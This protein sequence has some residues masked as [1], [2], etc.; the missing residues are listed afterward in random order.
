MAGTSSTLGPRSKA[1]LS[2]S[3]ILSQCLGV[4][5]YRSSPP[6]LNTFWVFVY[7][8]EALRGGRG[9]GISENL[10]PFFLVP[11]SGDSETTQLVEVFTSFHLEPPRLWSAW[12]KRVR[13]DGNPV[14]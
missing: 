10:A 12:V 5:E 1:G 6:P 2:A 7:V 13:Q 14:V 3:G 9:R 11:L 8:G 4:N